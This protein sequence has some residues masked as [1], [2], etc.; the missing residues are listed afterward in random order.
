MTLHIT[1]SSLP[2]RDVPACA[3]CGR[4][5]NS[6]RPGGMCRDCRS[7]EGP[8][9]IPNHRAMTRPILTPAD[10]FGDTPRMLHPIGTPEQIDAARRVIAAHAVDEAEARDFARMVGI[11]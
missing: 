5:L 7:I 6:P 4:D 2:M 9:M 8:N 3:R 11:S 10:Q 1:A